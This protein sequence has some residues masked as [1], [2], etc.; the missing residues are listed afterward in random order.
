MD[1]GVV[2]FRPWE[3]YFNC[4]RY[5]DR[6]SR[7][8]EIEKAVASLEPVEMATFRAWFE[9]FDASLWDQQLQ[10]DVESGKLDKIA[11]QAIDDFKKGKSR[12][13]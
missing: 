10:A 3:T 12:P 6:M 7:V 11:E 4:S 1:D 8:Q 2:A 5:G 13:L 9:E